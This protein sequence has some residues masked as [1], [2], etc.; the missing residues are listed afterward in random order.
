MPCPAH[1]KKGH[2]NDSAKIGFPSDAANVNY[3]EKSRLGP[4][5]HVLPNCTQLPYLIQVFPQSPIT[6]RSIL[7]EFLKS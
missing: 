6:T 3:A 1:K 5:G 2:I 7:I 4:S